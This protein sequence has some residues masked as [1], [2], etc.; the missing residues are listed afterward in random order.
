MSASNGSGSWTSSRRWRETV[1]ASLPMATA[2]ARTPKATTT[3]PVF[4]QASATARSSRRL[5]SELR[6]LPIRVSTTFRAFSQVRT[7]W[8]ADIEGPPC[9]EGWL[10]LDLRTGLWV[11]NLWASTQSRRSAACRWVGE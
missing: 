4:M 9:V 8:E 11:A 2:R 7:C 5:V 6:S 10:V 3:S 1:L